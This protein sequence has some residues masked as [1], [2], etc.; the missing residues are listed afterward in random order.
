MKVA[1]NVY[2]FWVTFLTTGVFNLM[3][4]T[5]CEKILGKKLRFFI[6]FVYSPN[7]IVLKITKQ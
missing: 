4:S 3:L 1:Q 5:D 2:T 7:I 6:F